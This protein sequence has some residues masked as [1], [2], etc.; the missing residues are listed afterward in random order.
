MISTTVPQEETMI[1]NHEARK[2]K[3][4]NAYVQVR[5]KPMPIHLIRSVTEKVEDYNIFKIKMHQDPASAT[6]EIY[7]LKFATFENG[8]LKK[9]LQMMKDFKTATDGTGTMSATVKTNFLRTMLR[10]EA[11]RE[12]NA[13]AYQVGSTTKD[14]LKLIKEVLHRYFSPSTYLTSRNA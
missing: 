5:I 6:S 3:W 8:K 2:S 4:L 9:I 13:L 7:N 14:H 1:S 12:F 11:L 10:G